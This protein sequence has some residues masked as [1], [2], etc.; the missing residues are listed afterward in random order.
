MKVTVLHIDHP[1]RN[2][3]IYSRAVVES[4][5][6]QYKKQIE[7]KQSIGVLT[8]YNKDDASCSV[9]LSKASHI[10]NSLEIIGDELVA[11]IRELDTP[12]GKILKLMMLEEK[13]VFR[14]RGLGKITSSA[15][16]SSTFVESQKAIH[17]VSDYELI[18]IDAIP[19]N[20]AS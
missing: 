20:T 19:A 18:S 5:I 1:N 15:P 14:P 17:V 6:G 4:A 10:V 11:D 8:D 12:S 9:D 16:A 3:R 13:I 7:E 2:N